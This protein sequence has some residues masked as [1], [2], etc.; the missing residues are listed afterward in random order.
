MWFAPRARA[1]TPRAA[2][3]GAL[4]TSPPEDNMELALEWL[5]SQRAVMYDPTKT[6]YFLQ[7]HF[8]GASGN[9]TIYNEARNEGDQFFWNYLNPEAASYF[10]SSVT[11]SIA[12]DAVDGTF[13]DDVDGLPAEHA[14]APGRMNMSDADLAALRFATQTTSQTLINTLIAAGKYNCAVRA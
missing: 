7:Y 10:V 3:Y 2:S 1:R 6:D 13:T 11:A 5:E 8:S 9:G 14:A 4:L 12:D